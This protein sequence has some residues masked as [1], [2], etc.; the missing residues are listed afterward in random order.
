MQIIGLCCATARC[1]PDSII[2]ISRA[3]NR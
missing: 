3:Q 1:M 2:M